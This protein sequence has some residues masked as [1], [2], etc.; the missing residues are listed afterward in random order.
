MFTQL[1]TEEKQYTSTRS[2]LA[3]EDWEPELCRMIRSVGMGNGRMPD[4]RFSFEPATLTISVEHLKKLTSELLGNALKFSQ[5]GDTIS[6]SGAFQK[7]GY[8]FQVQDRGCGMEKSQIEDVEPMVQFD[9]PKQVHSGVGLGLSICR[10]IA[11]RYR[12]SLEIVPNPE[13]GL[14][15]TVTL[16]ATPAESKAA[17]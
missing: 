3:Y 6:I 5:D 9:R 11:N 15:V 4:L 7:N 16:P 10:L 12:G 13:K 1:S 2:E 14:T 8:V 17:V